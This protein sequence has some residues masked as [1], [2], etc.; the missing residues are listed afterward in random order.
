M[1]LAASPARRSAGESPSG[2]SL[3]GERRRSDGTATTLRS[4]R[5]DL[6][7]FRGF[8]ALGTSMRHWGCAG[9]SYPS[10][11]TSRSPPTSWERGSRR[12]QLAPIQPQACIG[13]VLVWACCV[14]RK[15]SPHLAYCGWYM[16]VRVLARDFE[17]PGGLCR[18]TRDGWRACKLHVPYAMRMHTGCTRPACSSRLASGTPPPVACACATM[19]ITAIRARLQPRMASA[20]SL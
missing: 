5:G 9:R 8:H 18:P 11:S 17:A 3:R 12:E 14:R 16:R 1:S 7:A 4:C 2:R 20:C 15:F 19:V 6:A 13:R 10:H